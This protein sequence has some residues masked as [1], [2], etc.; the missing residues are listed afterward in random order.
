M[1]LV[2]QIIS[3]H[4]GIPLSRVKKSGTE[5]VISYGPTKG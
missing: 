2:A 4:E 5:A 3:E 1:P